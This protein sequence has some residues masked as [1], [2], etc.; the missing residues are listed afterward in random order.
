[1]NVS[2]GVHKAVV[3]FLVTIAIV[4]VH[5]YVPNAAAIVDPILVGLASSLDSKPQTP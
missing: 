1:M 4:A 3:T 5:A 2:F